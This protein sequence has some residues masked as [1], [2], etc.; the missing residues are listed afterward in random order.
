MYDPMASADPKVMTSFQ[1]IKSVIF[2]TFPLVTVHSEAIF[3]AIASIAPFLS[4]KT[5]IS[6][7]VQRRRARTSSDIVL[8]LPK[9]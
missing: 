7:V 4:D 2:V 3:S 1:N 8:V 6:L 9:T 5:M